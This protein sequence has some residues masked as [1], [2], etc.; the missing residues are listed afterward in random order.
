MRFLICLILATLA[1]IL[2]FRFLSWTI[3]RSLKRGSSRAQALLVAGF[4]LRYVAWGL[5]LLALMKWEPYGAIA[6]LL[7]FL[8]GRV[9]VTAS[10]LARH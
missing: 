9:I 3:D 7:G 6:A 2:Y 8:I 5:I 1:G 10:K 4:L